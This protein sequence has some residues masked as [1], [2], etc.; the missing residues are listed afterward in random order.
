MSS[1]KKLK[2]DINGAI[3]SALNC[4]S[5]LTTVQC[6]YKVEL[7]IHTCTQACTLENHTQTP[8]KFH[9]CKHFTLAVFENLKLLCAMATTLCILLHIFLG[10]KTYFDAV[11]CS[12]MDE[13]AVLVPH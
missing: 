4:S 13:V 7:C 5:T 1:L 11:A 10:F 9:H 8:L 12:K 3:P 2:S 6:H